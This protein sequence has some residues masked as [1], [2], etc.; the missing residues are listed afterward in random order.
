M[1]EARRALHQ[2]ILDQPADLDSRLSE[3]LSKFD[4]LWLFA[5]ALFAAQ[6]GDVSS[7]RRLLAGGRAD[8]EDAEGRSVVSVAASC[9]QLAVLEALDAPAQL[10]RPA[11]H[12]ALRLA[13]QN[14]Q[15][16]AFDWLIALG[17]DVNGPD[18]DGSSTLQAAAGRGRA[19]WIELLVTLGAD[20][21]QFGPAA[22]LRATRKKNEVGIEAMLAVMTSPVPANLHRQL[23]HAAREWGRL[24]VVRSIKRLPVVEEPAPL[25]SAE[26]GQVI[27]TVKCHRCGDITLQL[28]EQPG[29][30]L[31]HLW[32]RCTA[33]GDSHWRDNR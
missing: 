24:P 2:A 9:G 7:M 28:I 10:A 14:D 23:V 22:L 15:R 29:E 20:V 32:C 21:A 1:D 16:A 3:V 8:R 25:I 17:V 19:S 18:E 31:E 13:V 11:L 30:G 27:D 6:Q 33:C 4:D 5:S 12:R 26:G